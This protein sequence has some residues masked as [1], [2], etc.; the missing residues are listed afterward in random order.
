MG[1][2]AV[3]I[4]ATYL[5]LRIYILSIIIFILIGRL[6]LFIFSIFIDLSQSKGLS[7]GN[8]LIIILLLIAIALPLSYYKRIVHVGA[9]RE[10]YFK[11][12]QFV[13][14]VWAAAIALFNSLWLVFEVNVLHTNTVDLIKAFHW[15]DFGLAGSFL[16]QTAFYLMVMALLSM[17][18]SGYYHP[19][20]WLLSALLI[21]A[22][23][24]GTAIPSLRVH[25][26]FFFKTLLF[27]SSL[28]AGVGINLM[29][30]IIFV[31]GGWF[32]T[33]KRTY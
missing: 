19:V 29:F 18:V 13:F 5:Q 3:H 14:A 15:D 6:T 21:A 16:Y 24:I 27:S 33:R 22:I 32:F 26:V 31:A 17:L 10:Q 9:S 23:P 25:V 2:L 28:L 30:Y 11:G 7:V 1:A 12:L 4:K 8:M 20:G